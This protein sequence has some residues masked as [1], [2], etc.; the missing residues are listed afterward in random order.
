[1]KMNALV[2]ATK[3]II[4]YRESW[5]ELNFKQEKPTIVHVDNEGVIAVVKS[6]G[7]DNRSIYLINKINFIRECVERNIIQLQYINS[8]NNLADLGTKSLDVVQQH[9]RLL[10]KILKGSNFEPDDIICT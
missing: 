8:E 9:F 3:M 4:Y 5:E 6:F 2:E 7:K 10:E 1:V